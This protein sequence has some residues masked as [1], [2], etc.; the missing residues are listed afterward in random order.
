MRFS[1]LTLLQRVLLLKNKYIIYIQRV[2][3]TF[4]INEKKKT[5]KTKENYNP[6]ATALLLLSTTSSSSKSLVIR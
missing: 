6:V 4:N 2:Y 5:N 1:S 3:K